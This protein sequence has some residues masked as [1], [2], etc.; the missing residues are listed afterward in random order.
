MADKLEEPVVVSEKDNEGE[1]TISS[2]IDW[3]LASTH[4]GTRTRHQC[5]CKWANSLCTDMDHPTRI[6]VTAD[7][8]NLIEIILSMKIR[9]EY[10]V[11]WLEV[12][13]RGKWKG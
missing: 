7:D 8:I 3:K 6:W 13:K 9:D 5:L 10:N 4:V 11:N 1:V 12:L 2:L